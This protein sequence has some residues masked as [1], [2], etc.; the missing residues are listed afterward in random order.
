MKTILEDKIIMSTLQARSLPPPS[1]P[2]TFHAHTYHTG[3]FSRP[4]QLHKPRDNTTV[5][6]G[7]YS[8]HTAI[9]EVGE[10]PASITYYFFVLVIH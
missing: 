7:L 9:G 3:D 10:S 6:D 8:L 1:F 5:D 4:E 2:Q